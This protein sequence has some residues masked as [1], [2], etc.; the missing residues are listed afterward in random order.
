MEQEETLTAREM[1]RGDFLKTLA[2]G[3]GIAGV[4]SLMGGQAFADMEKKG[5]Y[6]F[7][8]THGGN[9]PNRAILAL[10]LAQLVADKGWGSVHVW[11][12]LEGRIWRIK[13]RPAG[14][15]RRSS[16]NSAMPWSSCRRRRG[17]GPPSGYVPHARNTQER[18]AATSSISWRRPGETG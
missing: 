3:A 12:T 13:T 10:I 9:D 5:K 15:N 7:V 11:M 18:S 17:R 1:G 6:V 14:S 8:I 2:A 4:A 16:R